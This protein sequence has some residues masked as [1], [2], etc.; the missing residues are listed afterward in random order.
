MD[1]AA[2]N[3]L[4]LAYEVRLSAEGNE[5]THVQLSAWPAKILQ[6][7]LGKRARQGADRGVNLSPTMWPPNAQASTQDHNR[8]LSTTGSTEK[9]GLHRVEERI[10]PAIST[11]KAKLVAPALPHF[12]LKLSTL[13]RRSM[14]N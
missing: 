8:V 3:R 1:T 10:H 11:A 5:M 13:H 9:I 4:C 14:A 7:A 12:E 6:E 2:R